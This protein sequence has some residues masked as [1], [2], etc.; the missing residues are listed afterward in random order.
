MADCSNQGAS[1]VLNEEIQGDCST[2]YPHHVIKWF[3]D[4]FSLL[5]RSLSGPASHDQL[6][7][8][9]NASSVNRGSP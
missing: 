1:G 3:N 4:A 6:L 9:C 8:R 5:V 2:P 7:S